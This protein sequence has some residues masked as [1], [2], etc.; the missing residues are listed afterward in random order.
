[1]LQLYVQTG[2]LS[3]LGDWHGPV[4]E[5]RMRSRRRSRRK[6]RPQ[7]EEDEE[8]QQD[9]LDNRSNSRERRGEVRRQHMSVHV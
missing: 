6:R 3:V 2:A 9:E 4:E 5:R 8:E 7:W 1:M